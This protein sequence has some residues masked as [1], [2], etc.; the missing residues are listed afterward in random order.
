M[1]RWLMKQL[2]QKIVGKSYVAFQLGLIKIRH[3]PVGAP[4]LPVGWS[5]FLPRLFFLPFLLI[6]FLDD[7]AK[8]S[9]FISEI[10]Q[11]T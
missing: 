9:T 8:K 4:N 2:A 7:F 10:H 6:F 3:L 5:F 1:P 11:N